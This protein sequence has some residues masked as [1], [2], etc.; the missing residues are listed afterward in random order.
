MSDY[1]KDYGINKKSGNFKV[2]FEIPDNCDYSVS[3]DT[4]DVNIIAVTL[5]PAQKDP[6]KDFVEYIESFDAINNLVLV[7]FELPDTENSKN[8]LKWPRKPRLRI[9]DIKM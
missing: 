9:D 2:A 6:S 1:L 8:T 3:I 7:D 5:K 4:D